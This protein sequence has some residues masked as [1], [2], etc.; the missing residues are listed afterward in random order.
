MCAIGSAKQNM[1]APST[2]IMATPI[3]VTFHPD[4][5]ARS[6]FCAPRFC[7]TI[8]ETARLNAING[9]NNNDSIR[10]PIAHDA[11]AA[12][13]SGTRARMKK[14]AKTLPAQPSL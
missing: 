14:T 7:P 2:S 13:C 3:S 8:D 11:R 9:I 6:S 4:F 10:M 5:M 1:Q 12:V